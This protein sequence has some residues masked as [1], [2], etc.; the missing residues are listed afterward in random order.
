MEFRRRWP[1]M[2]EEYKRCCRDGS[3][4]LADVFTWQDGDQTIFNLGTQQTWRTKAELWAIEAAVH[5]MIDW[6]EQHDLAEIG[7]PK[8]RAG[9]GGLQW[10]E[11]AEVIEKT[12]GPSIVSV[13]VFELVASVR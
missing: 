12:A 7:M 8:I 13:V 9:L 1:A 6:A 5:T 2:F 4:K 11:V 10:P 3:F